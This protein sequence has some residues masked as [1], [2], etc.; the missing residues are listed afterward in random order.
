MIKFLIFA[1]K[2]INKNVTETYFKKMLK[3]KRKRIKFQQN[4]HF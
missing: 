2:E 4:F 1:F 3:I